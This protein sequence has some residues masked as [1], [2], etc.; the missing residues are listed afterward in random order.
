MTL[1]H[2]RW[3]DHL[4]ARS[5]VIDNG[6]VTSFGHPAAELRALD[7][8]TVLCD[9]SHL[10]VIRVGGEDAASFLQAQLTC[11]LREVSAGAAR[12]GGYCSPKGRLL[13][14]FLIW[15][16]AGAF[17]LLLPEALQEPVRKRLSM[18]VLRAKAR[19]EDAAVATVRL[20]ISGPAA[21]SALSRCLGA[22]PA[23]PL[24]VQE[25]DGVVVIR[26]DAQRFVIALPPEQAPQLWDALAA[27]ATPAGA[28]C[29]DWLDLRAG[30][31]TV[32]PATQDQFVPQMANLDLVGG[33]SFSK[34][35]YPGQEIV[36]RTHYLGKLKRR[37]FLAHLAGDAPPA[38][39][40]E[41]FGAEAEGQASGMVAAVAPSPGGGWDLLA[42]AQISSAQGGGLRWKSP[43]GPRL[44]LL[45]L[46]YP[47]T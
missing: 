34:G 10:G 3:R 5:V 11:D 9:L 20:G 27:Q 31:A 18:F 44:E 2:P 36:A 16:S 28:A 30:I 23:A 6:R 35:C 37:M 41:L 33:V 24:A 19:L 46:P 25:R 12:Y 45:P 32:V 42:V 38:A 47:L 22:A 14:T 13:A 15:R 26:L 4:Q 39:G 40:D 8:G 1:I 43:D 21:E 17:H 29:W 7:G